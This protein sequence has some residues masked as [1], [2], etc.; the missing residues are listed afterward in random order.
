MLGGPEVLG[1]MAVGRI[2]TAAHVPAGLAD[3]QVYPCT[4]HCHALGANVLAIVPQ[5]VGIERNEV[6][7][8]RV[9]KKTGL[10]NENKA[11]AST[12][13]PRRAPAAPWVLT[14]H[15]RVYTAFL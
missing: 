6:L 3:A 4:A 11:G 9:H 5:V 7:A 15:S 1:R 10:M 14:A 8:K 12:E 13:S 2:I